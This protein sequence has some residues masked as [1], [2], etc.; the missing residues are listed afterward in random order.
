MA[1]SFGEQI[2]AL[3]GFDGD[4]AD[5]SEIGE[6][7]DD[8][9]AEWMNIAVREIVNLLPLNLLERSSKTVSASASYTNGTGVAH[10][11]R[12]LSIV[13]A[14]TA[15]FNAGEV[16]VCRQVS[17]QLSHKAADENGLSYA[18]E[19]DPVWYYEPQLDGTDIKIKVL[20]TSS[21]ALSK[22][23][24]IDY[25]VFDADGSG[26]NVNIKTSTSINNF[27]DEAEYLVVLKAAI[28]AAEYK[29]NFE[30]DIELYIPI[31]ANL[32]AR[33]EQ[34]I[35]ALQTR[36]LYKPKKKKDKDDDED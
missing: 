2:H 33:Y 5:A 22:V 32:K 26:N 11:N 19:T 23:N 9:T 28:L 27:P 13:R 30:E 36:K 12:I 24:S 7:Y 18:T 29:L 15:D 25:P 20:P 10:D 35:L 34:A 1:V 8:L 21:L 16:F 6:N 31:I 4:S 17:H 14:K 3:T